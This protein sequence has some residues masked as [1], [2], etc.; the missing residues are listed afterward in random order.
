MLRFIG[1]G[2]RET[3]IIWEWKEKWTEQKESVKEENFKQI[4]SNVTI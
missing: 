2:I 1:E 4:E 3:L